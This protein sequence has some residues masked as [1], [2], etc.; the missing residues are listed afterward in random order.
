MDANVL[1]QTDN[2]MMSYGVGAG[3]LWDSSKLR[4][5]KSSLKLLFYYKYLFH[6][7]RVVDGGELKII[8]FTAGLTF[9]TIIFIETYRSG[10]GATKLEVTDS[11]NMVLSQVQGDKLWQTETSCKYIK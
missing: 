5:A 7:D 9:L 6:C 4:N 3:I 2:N 11:G 1:F 8:T 10:K